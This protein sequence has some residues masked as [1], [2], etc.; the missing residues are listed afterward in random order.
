MDGQTHYEQGLKY[1]KEE[2][3]LFLTHH[4]LMAREL[5]NSSAMKYHLFTAIKDYTGIIDYLTEIVKTHPN[6]GY[7]IK[8]I[9]D[10]YQDGKGVDV[11][12]KQAY[13]WYNQGVSVNNPA[14]MCALGWMYMNGIYVKQNCETAIQMYTNAKNLG[15]VPANMYLGNFYYRQREF[16]K[17]VIM[18]EH[19][20]K[21]GCDN[22]TYNLHINYRYGYGVA[23]NNTQAY[24]LL[25]QA[26]AMGNTKAMKEIK[27]VRKTY[28]FTS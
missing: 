4:I 17:S 1:Q 7:F 10:V 22:C 12:F 3:W 5:G 6:Y 28:Y 13:E 24:K 11:N 20:M 2:N 21:L 18:Y 25:K 27:T 23:Q 16:K 14:C 9:G 19:G 8:F 15:Y 26:A